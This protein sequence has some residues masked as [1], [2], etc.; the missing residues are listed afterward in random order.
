[1]DVIKVALATV[2]VLISEPLATL[3]I[4]ADTFGVEEQPG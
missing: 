2:L 1:M 4:D 3:A